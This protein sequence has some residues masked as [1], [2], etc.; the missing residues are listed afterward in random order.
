MTPELLVHVGSIALSM[1]L[2]AKGADWTVD[3]SISIA[4]RLRMSEEVVG[5]TLV[6]FG[7][8]A[9][10]MVVTIVAALEGKPD[11]SVGNVVGSNIFNLGVI[12][13]GVALVWGMP[14]SRRI[15]R[16]DMRFLAITSLVMLVFTWNLRLARP[17][18]ALM[19]AALLV[20]VTYLIRRGETPLERELDPTEHAPATVR[21]FVLFILGLAGIIGGAQLLVW[22]ASELARGAGIPEWAIATTIVAGGT[23]LPELVTAVVAARRGH[24]GVMAGMLIGSDLFN[25][26]GVLGLAALLTPLAIEPPALQGVAGM[27]AMNVMLLVF[28]WRSEALG[29]TQGT[30]LLAMAAARWIADFA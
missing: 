8:S 12:M 16:R 10:E 9:P 2:L 3:A 7:T 19:L 29:R 20:Y 11:I 21:H 4:R 27:L 6:A 13:G 28:M 15:A 23:S 1:L 14:V 30:A 17:E 22:G 18:G 5:A 26:L 25:V 24:T